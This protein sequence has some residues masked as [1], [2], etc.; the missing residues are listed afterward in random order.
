MVKSI[1]DFQHLI[2]YNGFHRENQQITD[3]P[4]FNNPANGISAREDLRKRPHYRG[5]VDFKVYYYI[6]NTDFFN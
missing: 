4:S 3:D 6:Y 5:G 2:L 1:E